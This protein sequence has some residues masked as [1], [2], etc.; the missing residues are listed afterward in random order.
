MGRGRGERRVAL[1]G[2]ICTKE[3]DAGSRHR[4][5]GGQC[6]VRLEREMSELGLPRPGRSEL[7]LRDRTSGG[8][9]LNVLGLKGG[10]ISQRRR[11]CSETVEA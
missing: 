11:R 1:R 9:A 7:V 4:G 8:P 2:R 6:L 3:V 10:K 5:S